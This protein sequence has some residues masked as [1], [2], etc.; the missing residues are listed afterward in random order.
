MLS[1]VVEKE[2]VLD[3]KYI[4]INDKS[5]ITH[6]VNVYRLNIS[7]EIRVVDGEF[8]YLTKIVKISKKE[9][10]SEIVE[11]KEDNYSLDIKID[12]AMG[13]IKNDNMKLTIKKLTEIGVNSIIPLKT[14]RVVVKINEKKDVWTDTVKEAMK[15]C[16]AVRKTNVEDIKYLKELDLTKYDKVFFLYEN[17]QE[18]KKIHEIIK[19]SDRNILCIIGPEGGFTEKEVEY[20][21]NKE[22]IEI[23]LGKRILRAE[24]A[25]IVISSI[26]ANAW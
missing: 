18:N 7:D 8:E 11:K 24:T 6:I 15:Q 14:E 19:K 5:D 26:I 13:I 9:V 21:R 2:N 20:M 4:L 1:I 12:I 10:L 22:M 16:R 3:N 23:S 17:S 25:A